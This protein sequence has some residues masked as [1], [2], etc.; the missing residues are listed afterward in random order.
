[1]KFFHATRD[2]EDEFLRYY[3]MTIEG[4]RYFI[5]LSGRDLIEEFEA[6]DSWTQ[7]AKWS[8]VKL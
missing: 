4:M 7:N 8:S 1:M 2:T 6:I 5:P 3:F